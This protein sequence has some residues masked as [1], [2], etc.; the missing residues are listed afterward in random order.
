MLQVKNH[1]RFDGL[2]FASPTIPSGFAGNWTDLDLD[3]T[4]SG[5][6]IFFVVRV[7]VLWCQ[8]QHFKEMAI[9]QMDVSENSGTPKSSI[10]IGFSIKNHPFFWKHPNGWYW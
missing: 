10:L 3:S 7:V 8:I 1:I 6:V 5:A 9:N 2:F 4:S